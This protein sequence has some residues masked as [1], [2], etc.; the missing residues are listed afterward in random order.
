ML[1]GIITAIFS[2]V[3]LGGWFIAI[4]AIL[5]GCFSIAN[6]MFVSVRERTRIIGIQKA[7]GAKSS[8]I[9]IQFLFESIALCVF[10]AILA[11]IAIQILI[12]LINYAGLGLNLSVSIY[13][14][15]IAMSIAVVSGL[16]SGIVPALKAA[17]MPPVDAMRS[18]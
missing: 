5:V 6:I 17:N 15:G 2:Q 7:L 14:V 4:F 3:E 13:R 18:T 11:L 12:S 1:T 8:F 16:V 9:L 10:G